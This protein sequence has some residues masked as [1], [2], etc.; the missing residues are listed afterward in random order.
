[1]EQVGSLRT[2]VKYK[3]TPI[4]KIPVDW[5]VTSL[6]NIAYFEYGASLPGKK[7]ME[8]NVPVYGSGG[9]VGYHSKALVD[10]PGVIV[11]RKGTVGAV[12]WADKN[13]WPTDTTYYVS[14]K[15]SREDLKWLFYLLSNLHLG[16]LNVTTGTRRLN[17]EEA[18]SVVVPIPPGSEQRKIAEILTTVDETIEKS[19]QIIDKTK[20]LEKGLMRSLVKEKKVDKIL[21]ALDNEIEKESNY[22]EH[23]KLLKK[24]LM[25]VLLTGK[26]RVEV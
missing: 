2:G 18:H 16:R 6:G 26:L 3:D 5:E 22:K 23:L 7:P 17:R 8:G 4:G 9:F 24:G 11:G 10:G 15:Q 19:T 25:Q 20:E 14:T 12:N 21:N 13:F 1:V